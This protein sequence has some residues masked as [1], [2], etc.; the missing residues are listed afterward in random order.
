MY[1]I[2]VGI[3]L[4]ILHSLIFF[5]HKSS[6]TASYDGNKSSFRSII[7]EETQ[8]YGRQ[9]SNELC[10]FYIQIILLCCVCEGYSI[11]NVTFSNLV[12]IYQRFGS[13]MAL[14]ILR[15]VSRIC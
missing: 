13:T 4:D 14:G 9:S 3:S 6:E 8:D 12:E 7:F 1:Q 11:V 2:R 15:F 5:K 10:L